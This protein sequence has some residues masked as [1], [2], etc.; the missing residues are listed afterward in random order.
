[1]SSTA[2]A[3]RLATALGDR[4]VLEHELGGGGMSHVWV[5]REAALGRRVV[6]KVLRED[7][8]AGV[9]V[10]RFRRE[11]MLAAG[12]QHPHLLSVLHAGDADGTPFYV[13]PYV[14]GE[15]VRRKLERGDAMPIA[16]VV[17]ILR[18]VARALAFAHARGIVHRDIKPDNVLLSGGSAVVADLGIAKALSSSRT[19][20]D[21]PTSITPVP[22]GATITQIGMT[23]GT[24]AYMAPEQWAGDPSADHRV[25]LYA[26][27]VMAFE[28]LTGR[29][30]F[31]A[32]QGA[33][34]MK[35]HL[36]ESPPPVAALRPEVTSALATLVRECLAKDPDDRPASADVVAQRL[37]DPAMISGAVATAPT[38]AQAVVL[39]RRWVPRVVGG[40]AALLAVAL[41]MWIARRPSTDATARA[42]AATA[43]PP[44]SP[45]VALDARTVAIVPFVAITDDSTES[46]TARALIDE[47]STALVQAREYAVP[48]PSTVQDA[49]AQHPSIRQAAS[50]LHA[51]HLIEGTVQREGEVLRVAV[52]L[53]RTVDGEMIWADTYEGPVDDVLALQTLVGSRVRRAIGDVLGV[54]SVRASSG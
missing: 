40:G 6:V 18:D 27:G 36:T 14:D 7:R 22:M 3:D 35:A 44:A 49:I 11:V 8:A 23:V 9:S 17:S 37:A 48:S 2:L 28:L 42:L 30:P 45:A 10:E 29:A 12:L 19:T 46:R 54:D 38:L 4:Y 25:D 41:G 51:A 5:A 21:Q 15:S 50:A 31:A 43:T 47:V 20:G 24:P 1:M 32:H 33:A 39:R 26:L 53:V 16:Q 52:R 34:L 13:M